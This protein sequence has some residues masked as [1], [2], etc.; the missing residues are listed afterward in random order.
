MKNLKTL[1]I[2]ELKKVNAGDNF[3]HDVGC[4]I[5]EGFFFF[6]ALNDGLYDNPYTRADLLSGPHC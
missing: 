5:R 6:I 4:A 3:A 2:D 1:N